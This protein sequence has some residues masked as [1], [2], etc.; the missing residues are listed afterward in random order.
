MVTPYVVLSLKINLNIYSMYLLYSVL[1]N[2]ISK[3]NYLNI[4]VSIDL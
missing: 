4:Q 1:V 3:L 2:T